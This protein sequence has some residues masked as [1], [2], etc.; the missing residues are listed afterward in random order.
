MTNSYTNASP[1][2]GST[3]TLYAV[4]T[5]LTYGITFDDNAANVELSVPANQSALKYTARTALNKVDSSFKRA[6]FT[7]LGWATEND[8]TVAVYA[9]GAAVTGA[10]LGVTED[11]SEIKLYAVWS[12]N[13]YDVL[14][15]D[16]LTALENAISGTTYTVV[17]DIE[18]STGFTVP[19][20]VTLVIP[21]EKKIALASGKVD[22]KGGITLEDGA[23]LTLSGGENAIGSL[24]VLADAS[25]AGAKLT[26]EGTKLTVN[27]KLSVADGA[28]LIAQGS[29]TIG[30]EADVEVPGVDALVVYGTLTTSTEEQTNALLTEVVI[31]NE[32]DLD[33]ITAE[34]PI[35]VATAHP[36]FEAYGV[37]LALGEDEDAYESQTQE[38]SNYLLVL[39]RLKFANIT[40]GTYYVNGATTP[41]AVKAWG[42]GGTNTYGTTDGYMM[43]K[44]T[45]GRTSGWNFY[46]VYHEDETEMTDSKAF[47]ITFNYE[48]ITKTY[49]GGES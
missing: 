12:K 46:G 25:V 18:G 30:T 13:P 22:G 36:K 32:V 5:E 49:P 47:H 40:E 39:W 2:A 7:F 15:Q 48:V 10:N 27:A 11:N 8:A 37:S 44:K 29:L 43:F 33:D 41:E 16:D 24:N 31:S 23:E 45:S 9:D 19:A 38:A 42:S 28:K 26:G 21:A 35:A 4:W 34:D 6:G 1:T 17:A 3:V 14:S 20:G